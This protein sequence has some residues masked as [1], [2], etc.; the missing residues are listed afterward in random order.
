MA[1]SQFR[2]RVID[3]T[4]FLSVAIFPSIF[5]FLL[6]II[7]IRA[8]FFSEDF[9]MENRKQRI[10]E[11]DYSAGFRCI[12]DAC[13]HSCCIGWEIDIDED[14]YKK[15]QHI[16]GPVGEKLKANIF[17][18]GR[19]S[20]A[21]NTSIP[22]TSSGAGID[23]DTESD[24]CVH[25]ILGSNE[26]C[27]FLNS[28]N[29]CELILNLG[30]DSLCEICTEHPRFYKSFSDHMEMGFGM[31]CEEAARLLLSHEAPIRLIG[32]PDGEDLRSKVFSLLQDRTISLD[33]RIENI[34]G[35]L[36]GASSAIRF[37]SPEDISRW[38]AFLEG[39]E[40]LDPAWDIEIRKLRTAALTPSDLENFEKYM[41]ENGRLFEYENLLWYLIYRHLGEDPMEDEAL[42]CIEFSVLS[43]KI[44]R[45]LGACCFSEKSAFGKEDQIELCRMFS[46]EIEYSDENI[47][48]IYDHLFD[49]S[50]EI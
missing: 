23:P 39:L 41:E 33:E 7:R 24:E 14:T 35:L 19:S 29:L 9:S 15:Y 31:C 50:E 42:L 4:F 3:E 44:I 37:S 36:S 18:P 1:F 21:G 27:P 20:G 12:A 6:P 40:R 34:F 11:P 45:Y 2:L 25:F 43:M 47:D 13:R 10:I 17:V 16:T 26:R 49:L 22:E 30:E 32:L 5:F 48:L 38:G 8:T 28:D 46:S